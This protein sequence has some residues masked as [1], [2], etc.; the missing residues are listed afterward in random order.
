MIVVLKAARFHEEVHI[1]GQVEKKG[2][3]SPHGIAAPEHHEV[4]LDTDTH[5]VTIRHRE[6]ADLP[7]T[8]VGL[9]NVRDMVEWLPPAP[10]AQ[11][12]AGELTPSAGD[13]AKEPKRTLVIEK[14]AKT[15]KGVGRV[16]V[17]AD[18]D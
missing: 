4:S 8:F 15:G 3:G 10:V 11:E 18:D 16:T 2:I 17:D 1:P 12:P 5:L 7:R 9:S 13:G 6:R 14:S